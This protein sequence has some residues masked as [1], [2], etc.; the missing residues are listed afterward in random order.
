MIT[1]ADILFEAGGRTAQQ[2]GTIVRRTLPARQGGEDAAEVESRNDAL[3]YSLTRSGLYM[4]SSALRSRLQWYDLDDDGVIESALLVVESSRENQALQSSNLADNGSPWAGNGDFTI[5]SATSIISGQTAYRHTNGGT[6]TARVR[7]QTIGTCT[8]AEEVS[9]CV[10]E[11]DP[12]NPAVT[13]A[14]DFGSD[15][16]L[17]SRAT[18]TW[19]TGAVAVTDNEGTGTAFAVRLFSAGPNAGGEVYL[20]GIRAAG[21]SAEARTV[22]LYPTGIDQNTKGVYVHHVQHE[23]DADVSPPSFTPIITAGATVTRAAETLYAP[24]YGPTSTMQVYCKFVELGGVYL[25]QARIMH[26]GSASGARL[27]IQTDGT[28]GN[29]RYQFI[30]HNGTT[31]V[32]DEAAVTPAYGDT[33]EVLGT[34]NADG[35]VLATVAINGTQTNGSVSGALTPATTWGANEWHIGNGGGS[36]SAH[37]GHYVQAAT[38]GVG[39]TL[40]DFRARFP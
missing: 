9:F 34:L 6:S 7:S 17:V 4:P 19:A 40:D 25:P 30:H 10:L 2:L 32:S 35:S 26:L 14:I 23:E 1:D 3:G 22:E 39:F 20:F 13:S 31:S 8:G 33:V 11:Q 36:V 21:T 12:A 37:A 38:R 28:V 15:S 29:S 24:F 18:L 16:N 27:Y 5:A